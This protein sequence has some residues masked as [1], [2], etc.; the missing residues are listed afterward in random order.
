M[1]RG[2]TGVT[3]VTPRSLF[4]SRERAHSRQTSALMKET[5]RARE[6]QVEMKE[7]MKVSE[8]SEI[9]ITA[10]LTVVQLKITGLY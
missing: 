6:R 2:A 10:S 8:C 7:E 3:R 5:I 9:S 1:E 4:A